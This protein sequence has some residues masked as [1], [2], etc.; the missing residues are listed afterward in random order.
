M[1]FLSSLSVLALASSLLNASPVAAATSPAAATT[2]AASTNAGDAALTADEIVRRVQAYYD[3]IRDFSADFSQEYRSASLGTTRSS[4]GHVFFKKPGKMRWDYQGEDERYL[5]SDGTQL[6][7]YEPGFAQYYNQP[8]A[9]SQLP[10]ALRFLMGEGQLADDF[11]VR[12]RSQNRETIELELV[13][14]VRNS[15][16]SRLRFVVNATTFQVQE[17][18]IQ[19]ALGNT[20]RLVFSSVRQ[21]V[22][23]PD[24]G[25]SFSPPAGARRVEAPAN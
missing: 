14:K 17:T 24:S 20:N 13:P 2:T 9:D 25:F 4:S 5:I 16:F 11:N 1:S 19:D 8:L 12:V 7:V 18:T 10:S 3:G 15:Q 23:L 21:N 22:G 6:W